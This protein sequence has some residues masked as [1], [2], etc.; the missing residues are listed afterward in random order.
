MIFWITVQI[1]GQGAARPL[2]SGCYSAG[3]ASFRNLLPPT[4]SCWLLGPLGLVIMDACFVLSCAQSLNCVQLSVT[5]WTVACQ[6]PLSV[7]IL[8]ARILQWLAVPR[9]Q[10]IF[11]TQELKPGL[12]Q[13]EFFLLSEPPGKPKNTG[14]SSLSLLQEIF[15][16]QKS[17]RGLLH[18]S[19]VL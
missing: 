2:D 16:T 9:L 4:Y 1:S 3:R 5:P 7:G 19:F 6:A 14:V 13:V 12:P 15:S 11:P 17:N 10:G 8:Q 18:C